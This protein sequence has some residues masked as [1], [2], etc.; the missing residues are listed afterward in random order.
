MKRKRFFKWSQKFYAGLVKQSHYLKSCSY[1][2]FVVIRAAKKLYFSHCHSGLVFDDSVQSDLERKGKINIC[3]IVLRIIWSIWQ[4][5][6]LRSGILSGR[7]LPYPEHQWKIPR[8]KQS[9]NPKLLVLLGLSLTLNLILP[10]LD[11][12][13]WL[14]FGKNI[15]LHVSSILISNL[16]PARLF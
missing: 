10:N 6:S 12:V 7:K 14:A 16:M 5:K 4:I 2:Y 13:A 11:S 8:S 3:R 9:H 15:K 1:I